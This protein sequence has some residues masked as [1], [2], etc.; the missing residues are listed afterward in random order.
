MSLILVLMG[1]KQE[2]HKFEA[3]SAQIVIFQTSLSYI[4]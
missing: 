4:M 3:S 1:K 2:E